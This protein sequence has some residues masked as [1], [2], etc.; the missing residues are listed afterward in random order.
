MRTLIGALLVGLLLQTPVLN[1]GQAAIE[2][3]RVRPSPERT[4]IVFDL[5]D[6]VEHRVFSLDDPARLVIDIEDAS[7][8][9]AVE[10]I[11]LDETPI[12]RM[13]ASRRD[14]TDLRVVL[15]LKT[16]VKPRSFVLKPILQYGDRLVV[17]LYT[18]AQQAPMVQRV[19][20]VTRQ[21]RDVVIAIDAGHGGDDPGAI[22][23]GNLYEKHVTLAISQDLARL[24]ERE[25]G[26]KPLLVREGD[27]FLALRERTEIARTN[28]ADI[29]LSI[30]ADAFHTAEA[31]GASV[32]A[33]SQRGATSEA[34]RWLAEKENR[35]DLIGGA[36]GVSLGDKDDLLAGVLLDLS[37]TASLAA[38]LE[39]GQSVLSAIKPVN[40][41]HKKQVE[42]AGFAVLKSPDIPSLL[43]ET[44]YISNPQEAGKLKTRSHQQA[45]A[46]AIF[47]GVKRFVEESPPAGSYIAWKRQGGD[48]VAESHKTVRGDTLSGIAMKYRVD[49]EDIKRVNGLLGDTIRVGQVL[50]IPTS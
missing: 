29:F 7:L 26:F 50:K 40:R 5:S 11:E 1:A 49:A 20:R 27:Y 4:R 46:K 35:A 33:L 45:M 19:D 6:A 39:M 22:G 16:A 2:G 24:F 41:L 36:G 37:M 30:H 44:G 34:A 28:E 32:Y 12:A 18:E 21:M 31:R 3:V 47:Y 43:I 8:S 48:A 15:D 42:Q 14:S 38:S 25:P 13:R 23:H 17:D 9:A 10:D